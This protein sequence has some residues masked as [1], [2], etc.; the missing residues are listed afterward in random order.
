MEMAHFIY[1]LADGHIDC[2]QFVAIINNAAMNHC[3]QILM[4][5]HFPWVAT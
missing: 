5:T 1:P 4:W 2:F 3:V